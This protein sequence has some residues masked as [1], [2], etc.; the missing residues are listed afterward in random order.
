MTE[1]IINWDIN[2]QLTKQE[3]HEALIPHLDNFDRGLYEEHLCEMAL[4]RENLSS[5]F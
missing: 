1:K 4:P 2:H 3:G 5:Q